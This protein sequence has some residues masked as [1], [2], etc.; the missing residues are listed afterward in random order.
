M[1][2]TSGVR[3]V[4]FDLGNT[5]VAYYVTAD[6]PD[7]LRQCLQA[8]TAVLG[9]SQDSERDR[10]MFIRAMGLN[11]ERPNCAVHPLDHRLNELFGE[12]CS[13]DDSM[14]AAVCEAFMKPIFGL[15]RLDP[16]ALPLLESLRQRDIKTAIV[17]NSPW[18]SSAS[19]W[20]NEL[21]R[22][23]LLERVDVSVFCGDVGWRKPNS[24]PF[25]RALELI[26]VA[27]ADAIFVGDDPRWDVIG[28]QNAGLRP[29]LL[30]PPSTA[31]LEGC[32][33]ISRLSDVLGLLDKADS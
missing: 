7:V 18:G 14:L 25:Q 32:I 15:A 30:R 2:R 27:P 13:L 16:D 20:R 22:H 8:C 33:G 31:P 24:A 28:A 12:Y 5:L 1:R 19:A 17:S 23:G 9:W 4:L 29:V 3:A 10:A 11:A 26:Q 6:F 21:A